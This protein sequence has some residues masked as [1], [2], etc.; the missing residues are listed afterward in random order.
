MPFQTAT[1]TNSTAAIATV[2]QGERWYVS[3][4][5]LC[6]YGA[7]IETVTLYAV[8]RGDSPKDGNMILK[9]LSIAAG[10]I[11]AYEVPLRLNSGDFISALGGTGALVC[12]QVHYEVRY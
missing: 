7:A 1:V 6:N 2:S 3:V 12:A 9:T 5:S 4:I 11:Y 8:P 10:G